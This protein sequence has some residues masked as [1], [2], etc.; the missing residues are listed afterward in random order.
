MPKAGHECYTKG[1]EREFTRQMARMAEALTD[2]GDGSL[3]LDNHLTCANSPSFTFFSNVIGQNVTKEPDWCCWPVQEEG[4]GPPQVA[5]EA[6]YVFIGKIHKAEQRQGP[7]P[8]PKG[9]PEGVDVRIPVTGFF[10]RNHVPPELEG[11]VVTLDTDAFNR[12]GEYAMRG[13]RK[14]LKRGLV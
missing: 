7:E 6:S 14:D 3:W 12:I 1:I 5:V 13:W 4:E 8:E 2:G 11:S 9:C 10:G